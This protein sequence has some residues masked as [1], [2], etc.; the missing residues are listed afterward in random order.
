MDGGKRTKTTSFCRNLKHIK[1]DKN[2]KII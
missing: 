2:Y 1:R